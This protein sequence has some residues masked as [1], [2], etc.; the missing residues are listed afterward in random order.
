MVKRLDKYREKRRFDNTPEPKG[1]ET[2]RN[3]AG[4][5]F[6]I[7][8]H[9]ASHLHWDFRVEIGGVLR[10][11]ALPKGIPTD[12]K[13]NRLA[14]QVEDHPLEYL[15]FFGEI[16]AGEYGAGHVF[17]W[18]RGTYQPVKIKD[19]EL[20]VVLRGN[21]ISG[22][23]VLF[24]TGGKNW[25]IHRMDPPAGTERPM[26]KGLTP[27]LAKPATKPP[28]DDANYG[29]EIKWDGLR[30]L[31]YS[32]HGYVKLESRN[33]ID[34]TDQFPELNK[35][36]ESLG[37]R[38]VILDGELIAVLA[39]GLPSFERLQ[40]RIGL[41]GNAARRR[42]KE[43]PISYII[44]DLLYLDGYPTTALS[45]LERR[46]LLAELGL[47]GPSWQTP[48]YH[49]GEG[50][51]FIEASRAKG[52]EGVIAKR[53]DSSYEPGKR[54]GAWLKIKNYRR[55]ELVIGGWMPGRGGRAG[56]I[57]AL[58]VGYYDKSPVSAGGDANRQ[59]IYAGSV[60]TGFN[61]ATLNDLARELTPLRLKASPF[62][63]RPPR[64][65]AVYV[66]PKLVA[67]V[68]FSEW[69]KTGLLRQASF[70]G[71]RRDK[72]AREV[73]RESGTSSTN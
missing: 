19:D 22:K 67:E 34:I 2:K 23:Y 41:S 72:D 1:K 64:P 31:F 48:D 33:G 44:F 70:K 65:D 58:L 27:M 59:L 71:L 30:A 15:D 56:R 43:V 32:D 18:D 73:V 57:G 21:R 63:G 49:T 39:N 54:S 17:V 61:E 10:S 3:G 9:H 55:Q 26:T 29:Y 8:E 5:R 51:A 45:Y 16:P 47:S 66:E 52:L 6:V 13:I 11:W 38:R 69:T 24:Q 40:S 4:L 36:G 50:S 53:L 12:P 60:G 25:I 14:V 46:R 42:V 68:A 7:Q 35:L 37:S 28:S 62:A 20:I